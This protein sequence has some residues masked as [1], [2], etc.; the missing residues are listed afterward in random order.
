MIANILVPLTLDS[1]SWLEVCTDE[2]AALRET[3]TYV[4]VKRS[5]VDP[6]NV[7]GC[8]WVFVLKKK[9]DGSIEHYKACIVTKGF[10]QIY[11]IMLE[12]GQCGGLSVISQVVRYQCRYTMS[13][14]MRCLSIQY[15]S[16][17]SVISQ[18]IRYCSPGQDTVHVHI[19]HEEIKENLVLATGPLLSLPSCD[20]T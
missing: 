6:H 18:V 8:W 19:Y 3:K 10:S 12:V 2:L 14:Y 7:V 15:N 17:L 5:E 16:H 13:F 1:D 11:M 4:P 9:V 20:E